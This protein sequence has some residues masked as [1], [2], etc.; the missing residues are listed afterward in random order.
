MFFACLYLKLL[1]DCKKEVANVELDAG[2]PELKSH[3]ET[4]KVLRPFR[5]AWKYKIADEMLSDEVVCDE[6]QRCS[7]VS[8]R[9]CVAC[10]NFRLKSHLDANGFCE[11]VSS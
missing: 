5:R 6:M 8:G 10:R 7:Y 3:T 11:V 2:N 1:K 9:T 4:R